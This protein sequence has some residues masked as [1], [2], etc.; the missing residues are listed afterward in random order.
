MKKSFKLTM[1]LVLILTTAVAV[2]GCTK[3]TPDKTTT[4]GKQIEQKKPD[5]EGKNPIE[6]EEPEKEMTDEQIEKL[7]EM[8]RVKGGYAV[9]KYIADDENVSIPKE[10]KGRKI[11]K[12][13][14]KAFADCDFLEKIDM[15]SSVEEIS[16]RAFAGCVN[17]NKVV[18]KNGLKTIGIE[19]FKRAGIEK[20][21]I[22]DSIETVGDNAFGSCSNLIKVSIALKNIS[23]L[24]DRV[25]SNFDDA[26]ISSSENYNSIPDKEF[27]DYR[28][29]FKKITFK[30]DIREIGEEAFKGSNIEEI[31]IPNATITEIKKGTF[32]D[33]KNLKRV[34]LNEGLKKIC[35]DAFRVSGIESLTTPST[36]EEICGVAK[37]GKGPK[38]GE[39]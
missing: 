38:I 4:P 18:L 24:T 39:I 34:I 5:E 20:I 17:L 21:N 27:K 23:L 3:K 12:I 33:C 13:E 30:G 25:F 32:E 10:Y 9:K 31:E 19:A 22:P 1:I 26:E 36:L 8:K 15:P 7:F 37:T 2:L 6:E 29:L 14:E 28:F 11:N 16:K 35:E